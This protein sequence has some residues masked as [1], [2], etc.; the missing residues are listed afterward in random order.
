[1]G[2]FRIYLVIIRLFPFVPKKSPKSSGFGGASLIQLKKNECKIVIFLLI[3]LN[4]FWVL[5]RTVSLRRLFG[6][7]TT[8]VLVEK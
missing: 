1:M 2:S 4:M 3:S 5:K 6:V 7:P 8:H